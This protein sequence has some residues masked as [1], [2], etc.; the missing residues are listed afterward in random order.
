MRPKRVGT[1]GV[2][3]GQMLHHD[4]NSAKNMG[5]ICTELGEKTDYSVLDSRVQFVG[6][7]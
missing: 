2:E 7:K 3:E 1:G 4:H 6:G 5:L